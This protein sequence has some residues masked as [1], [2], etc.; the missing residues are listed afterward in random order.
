MFKKRK[1]KLLDTTKAS[2]IL[3]KFEHKPEEGKTTLSEIIEEFHENGLL[4]TMIFFSL[5]V[6][7]PLP[8]P[9]G[10]TTII[11]IPIMILAV[12]MIFGVK[13]V[14]L[15]SKI[16]YYSI[17]NSTLRKISIKVIPIA[18]FIENHIK[19]RFD[20]AKSTYC[21]QF[22]GVV[23]LIAS[24]LIILP[25]PWANSIPAIGI[26]IMSLGLLG[27]DG[28]TIFI[29][30]LLVAIGVTIASFTAIGSFIFLKY[31]LENFFNNI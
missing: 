18:K 10:F 4:M 24:I 13:E 1:P 15:P 21:E 29:G 8:Y 3:R 27:R 23:S 26:S 16:K 25:L 2:D 7:I 30:F 31:L 9:P 20:F 5:P 22:V 14:K 12:Q 17:N 11:G 6:A 19:P 28:V